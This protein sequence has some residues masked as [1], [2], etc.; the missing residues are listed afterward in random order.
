MAQGELDALLGR[1]GAIAEAVNAFSSEAVQHEA[2]SALIAAFHGKRHSP[3]QM[4]R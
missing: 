1:M 3:A 4:P 2:F